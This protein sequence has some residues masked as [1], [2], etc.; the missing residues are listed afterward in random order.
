MSRLDPELEGFSRENWQSRIRTYVNVHPEYA[1]LSRWS[2]RETSDIV[3]DDVSGMFTALLIEKG[4][5][6]G[7]C[8]RDKTPRYYIEVKSTTEQCATPFFMSSGQYERVRDF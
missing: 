4:Y 7:D 8:W 2:G 5:L 3:Y 1:G 6:N